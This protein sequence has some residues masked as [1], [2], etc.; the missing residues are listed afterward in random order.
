MNNRPVVN[1]KAL[2][3]LIDLACVYITMQ[4]GIELYWFFQNLAL[5]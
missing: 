3:L 2:N 5:M 4:I 1:G